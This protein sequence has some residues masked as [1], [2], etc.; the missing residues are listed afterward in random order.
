M[1]SN[2]II[3][4]FNSKNHAFHLEKVLKENEYKPNL[5]NAP[6]YLSKSCS[7]AIKIDESAYDFIVKKISSNKLDVYRIYKVCY[8]NNEKIYMV[9]K[10]YK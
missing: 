6:G 7:M 5:Y 4:V 9:L 8:K 10:K 2:S 3:V 1:V